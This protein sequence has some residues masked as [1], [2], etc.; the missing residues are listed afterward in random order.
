ML[1][2]RIYQARLMSG[3]TQK[4]V[5][6]KLAELGYTATVAVISK[7]ELNKSTPPPS[8]LIKLAQIF[9][10]DTNYFLHTPQSTIEWV[11]YRKHSQLPKHTQE[12]IQAFGHDIADLQTELWQL[13]YP[14]GSDFP[15]AT[16]VNNTDEAESFAEALRAQWGLGQLPIDNLT[17]IAESKGMIIIRWIEDVGKFDGLSGWLNDKTPISIMN[18]GVSI[19]RRRFSL[20][21]ELG[22][23]LMNTETIHAE[24]IANR[25][26]GAFLVPKDIAYHELGRKRSSIS[27]H[28]LGNLKKRYGLSIAGWIFRAKNLGIISEDY[29]TQLWQDLNRLG[30]KQSEP[31]DYAYTAD[32][33]P[34]IL[35]QMCY[36]AISEGLISPERVLQVLP[37]FRFEETLMPES[38]F[39]TPTQLLAMPQEERQKWIDLSF[40]LAKDMEFERFDA[41]GEDY[42]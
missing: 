9:N 21:H 27:L 11:A 14:H 34:T 32:E 13:F 24:S 39:P 29:A 31:S 20:A 10:V 15:Q 23:L 8:L 40:E 38:D 42:F 36:R 22:H 6:E 28:E 5:A 1:G 4:Q 2:K 7:Y 26:A 37:D 41:F 3:L 35:E 33:T 17:H 18:T 25:F 12:K 30:W 16:T 19:D